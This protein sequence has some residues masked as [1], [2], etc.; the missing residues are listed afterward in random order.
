MLISIRNILGLGAVP[1]DRTSAT[2]WLERNSIFI[3]EGHGNG[4]RTCLVTLSDLPE[5][6]RIAYT[7]RQIA[8]AGLEA[9]TPDEAAHRHFMTACP[10][11]RDKAEHKAAIAG[12]LVSAGKALTWPQKA[13]AVAKTFGARGNSEANLK[14]LLRCV[15]GVDPA[16]FAPALLGR[17]KGSPKTAEI[18]D[19]DWAAFVC[20]LAEAHHTH[21]EVAAFNDVRR[22]AGQQGRKIASRATFRRRLLDLP[23][24]D[25]LTIKY[26]PVTAA[27]MLYQPQRRELGDMRAMEWVSPDCGEADT[28]AV[29][30][31]SYVSRPL[32][33]GLVDQASGKVLDIEIDKTENSAAVARLEIRTFRRFGS[34]DNL[35][36]DNGAA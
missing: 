31:D 29:W 25:R 23:V 5:P 26:G 16:N 17:H 2:Q 14:K 32:V 11:M 35:L 33:L 10:S 12:F 21:G 6:V 27:K 3:L 15:E 22:M 7:E 1:A 18:S 4:G 20:A 13:A 8:A 34:P 30:P 24:A 36:T 9:G 19:D 28:L